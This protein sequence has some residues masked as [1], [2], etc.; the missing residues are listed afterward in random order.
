MARTG[1]LPMGE[2]MRNA[3]R[4]VYDREFVAARR[5]ERESTAQFRDLPAEIQ[6]EYSE[7]WQLEVDRQ[8]A[9]EHL[10]QELRV[11][12][13]ISGAVLF[14]G[15]TVVWDAP[16]LGSVVA[17]AVI[18]AAT[19]W[20]WHLLDA[21]RFLCLGTAI[22]GYLLLRLMGPGQGPYTMF[23]GCVAM[24]AFATCAGVLREIRT[25]NVP[26]TLL[27]RIRERRLAGE[28]AASSAESGSGSEIGPHGASRLTL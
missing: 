8:V 9:R 5:A 2:E 17:A 10:K 22:P 16:T 11:Q 15:V 24:A 3:P 28:H 13:I 4:T 25:G 7:R 21:G 12:T 19:G 20:S 14:V 23:F 26:P 1:A 27:K 6:D 18:G